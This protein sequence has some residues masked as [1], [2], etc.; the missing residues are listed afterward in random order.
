MKSLRY[1]MAGAL[2]LVLGA[3]CQ[4]TPRTGTK[5]P[6]AETLDFTLPKPDG[7]TLTL[8]SLKGQVVLVDMWATWCAP[9]KVSFPFY[10]E[11]Q[12]EYEA[13]GFQILA[14]SVDEEDEAVTEFLEDMPMPFTV[15]RDPEGTVPAQLKIDTMPTAVLIGRD[16][17]IAFMHAGFV[18]EDQ[19]EIEEQVAAALANK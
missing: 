2:I 6:T 17:K 7:S 19:A 5:T 15:L 1:A 9:C 18:P 11:L 12:A 4:T 14:V 13:Q 16:G 10:A 3:A 8:S